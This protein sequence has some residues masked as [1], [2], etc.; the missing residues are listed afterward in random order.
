MAQAPPTYVCNGYGLCSDPNHWYH[1]PRLQSARKSRG[2]VIAPV[3]PPYPIEDSDDDEED[4]ENYVVNESESE[5]EIENNENNIW[6]KG[7][8]DEEGN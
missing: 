1:V 5:S 4:D 3:A 7:E 8:E 6:E 2:I